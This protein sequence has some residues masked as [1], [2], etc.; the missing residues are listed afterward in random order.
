[1]YMLCQN[2]QLFADSECK[3][4]LLAVASKGAELAA[5][6]CRPPK[7]VEGLEP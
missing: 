7:Y 6:Y 3:R 1:M 4:S 2:I 5:A